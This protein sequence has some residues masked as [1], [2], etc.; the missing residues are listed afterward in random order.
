MASRND[1]K[2]RSVFCIK[3]GGVPWDSAP[4]TGRAGAVEG[5]RGRHKSFPLE[6]G[7]EDLDVDLRFVAL[8][9]YTP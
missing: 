1:Q 3:K 7:L 5:V 8:S 4:T 2:L 9:S 6:L